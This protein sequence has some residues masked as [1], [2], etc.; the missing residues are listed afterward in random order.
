MSQ[1]KQSTQKIFT[2]LNPVAGRSGEANIHELLDKQ[3]T[4][5]GIDYEIYETT[6]EEEISAVSQ[7]ARQSGFDG[8]SIE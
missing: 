5:L 8:E 6:G 4:D 7:R 3:L 2:I 1:W